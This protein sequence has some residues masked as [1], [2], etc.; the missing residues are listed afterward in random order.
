MICLTVASAF[1]ISGPPAETIF[2]PQ[3]AMWD[4][5]AGATLPPMGPYVPPMGPYVPPTGVCLPQPITTVADVYP[6]PVELNAINAGDQCCISWGG[7]G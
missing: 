4:P 7:P 6:N 3:T 1:R 5:Q 2:T